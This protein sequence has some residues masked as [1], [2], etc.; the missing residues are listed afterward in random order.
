METYTHD[1][2]YLYVH[3]CLNVM[4]CPSGAIQQPLWN[5][6]EVCFYPYLNYHHQNDMRHVWSHSGDHCLICHHHVL[7]VFFCCGLVMKQTQRYRMVTRPFSWSTGPTDIRSA[8]LTLLQ[9]TQHAV[10]TATEALNAASAGIEDIPEESRNDAW[11]MGM[12]GGA[13]WGCLSQDARWT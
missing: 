13:S 12:G 9:D 8:R 10:Q 3:V 7:L 5:L 6:I 11:C 1:W 4:L 2:W